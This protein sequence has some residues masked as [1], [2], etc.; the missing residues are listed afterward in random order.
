[1]TLLVWVNALG[2][3]VVGNVAYPAVMIPVIRTLSD[4]LNLPIS[5]LAWALS[6]G[7]CLGGNGTL[8][9][10]AV[11]VV[12]VGF[13]ERQNIHLTFQDFVRCGMPTLLLTVAIGNMWLIIMVAIGKPFI[14]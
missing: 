13:A 1:M 14:G 9:G 2:T 10:V 5:A 7:A 8:L 4:D 12:A 6:L 3:S 11:N